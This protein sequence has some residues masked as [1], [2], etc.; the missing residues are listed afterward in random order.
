MGLQLRE[1][2]TPFVNLNS[3]G[4]RENGTGGVTSVLFPFLVFLCS[5]PLRVPWIKMLAALYCRGHSG[6]RL[7]T[8]GV[9]F[10][11]LMEGRLDNS[12]TSDLPAFGGGETIGGRRQLAAA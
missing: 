9:G 2:Q 11:L 7:T 5:R 10:R 4:C 3:S 8:D 6:T 12:S 1:K